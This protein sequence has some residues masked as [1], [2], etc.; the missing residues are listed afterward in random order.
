[1]LSE[2]IVYP[3]PRYRQIAGELISSIREGK[4]AMGTR[5]P[6]ELDLMRTY[7]VSRH[8]V[9]EA[10]RMLQDMQLIERRRGVGTLVVAS[11]SREAYIQSV[12]HPSELLSYP[13]D[14]RLRILST[15][16]ITL[17]KSKASE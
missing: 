8:T 16:S 3:E 5:M 11:E 7:K 14:S 17:S 4:F 15:N 12:K 6:G 2:S 13:N 1:M 10:L 9:R